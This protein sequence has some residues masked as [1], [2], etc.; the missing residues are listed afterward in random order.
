MIPALNVPRQPPEI[1]SSNPG[2]SFVL[3]V[4]GSQ[5]IIHLFT[6]PC[7]S[8]HAHPPSFSRQPKPSTRQHTSYGITCIITASPPHLP[9]SSS[10]HIS[11]IIDVSIPDNHLVARLPYLP[12][13]I[14]AV[15][16]AEIYHFPSFPIRYAICSME[17]SGSCA[18]CRSS[19]VIEGRWRCVADGVDGVDVRV[20]QISSS[21]GVTRTSSTACHCSPLLLLSFSSLSPILLLSF[22]P[23]AISSTVK[24][25]RKNHRLLAFIVAIPQRHRPLLAAH[26]LPLSLPRPYADWKCCSGDSLTEA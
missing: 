17:L 22:S 21:D 2:S 23:R 20:S 1:F 11:H 12:I 7:I 25:E 6:S 10:T 15:H 16:P 5:S 13:S 8:L 19:A 3:N 18:G 24:A 26:H 4:S 9:P 14:T